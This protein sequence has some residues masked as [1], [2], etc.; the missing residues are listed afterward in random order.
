MSATETITTNPRILGLDPYV[1]NG[2]GEEDLVTLVLPYIKSAREGVERLGQLLKTYGTY[3][4]NGIAFADKEEVWW[5]ETIGGHHWAAVR[6]PDDSYVV[7]PN[8]MNIDE[9]KFDNDDY[10]LSLIHI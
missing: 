3:E 1:E 8:R 5:L 2:M 6:I 7:A 4:P 10:M 9:F